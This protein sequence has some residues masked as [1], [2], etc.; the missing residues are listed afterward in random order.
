MAID[1]RGTEG[2]RSI[3]ENHGSTHDSCLSEEAFI[4]E[5]WRERVGRLFV[6]ATRGERAIGLVM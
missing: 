5:H 4:V 3:E 6:I 1:D 2:N